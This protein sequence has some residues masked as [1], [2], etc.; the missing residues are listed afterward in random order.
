MAQIFLI[1]VLIVSFYLHPAPVSTSRGTFWT[2]S[3]IPEGTLAGIV[4]ESQNVR[5]HIRG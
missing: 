2:Q 1:V 3:G 5:V 4:N